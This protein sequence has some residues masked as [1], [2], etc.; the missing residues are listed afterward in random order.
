MSRGLKIQH[1]GNVDIGYPSTNDP[2]AQFIG[3][4]GGD[5]VGNGTVPPYVIDCIANIEYAPGQ[6]A[7]GDAYIV[8]QKGKHK[9]LVAN[10]TNPSY[11]Q[12]CVLV[13]TGAVAANLTSSGTM[14]IR[15]ITDQTGPV[16]ANVYSIT[17]KWVYSFPPDYVSI[18]NQG[19]LS[20]SLSYSASFLTSNTAPQ[21]GSNLP[22][23]RVARQ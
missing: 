19:N 14:G 21:P 9:Y 10:V 5:P 22:I 1:N 23:A 7:T 8:R 6:Y 15:M 18:A 12:V 3:V 13:N 20:N 11:Q 16:G 4:V 2:A 17:N